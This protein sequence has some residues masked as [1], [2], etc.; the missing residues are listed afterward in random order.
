MSDIEVTLRTLAEELPT[1][2]PVGV[3]MARGTHLRTRRRMVSAVAAVALATTVA[4]VGFAGS[5][6]PPIGAPPKPTDPVFAGLDQSVV[7]EVLANP[8]AQQNTAILPV[9]QRNAM[10][11]GMVENFVM[12]RQVLDVYQSWTATGTAPS[13]PLPITTPQHPAASFPAVVNAYRFYDSEIAS[14]DPSRLR[15]DLLNHSGCGVWV[16]A[17]PGDSTGPTIADIVRST[18]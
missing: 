2:P 10:W 6:T 5:G 14:G 11:Q 17:N 8:Q 18:S 15:N 3:V 13:D 12:C 16:P 4:T 1:P 9:S 7:V